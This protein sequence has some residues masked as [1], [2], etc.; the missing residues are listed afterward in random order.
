MNLLVANRIIRSGFSA[1]LGCCFTFL[2]AVLSCLAAEVSAA[3]GSVSLAWSANTE[4]NVAGYRLQYGTV[5]G[6]YPESMDVGKVTTASAAGLIPGSTYYFTVVAYNT[7]GQISPPSAEVSYLVP[8][9]PNSAPTATAGSLTVLEDGEGSITLTGTDAENDALIFSVVTGPTRGTLSGTPPNL[10]YRPNANANGNDSFTFRANDGLLSSAVATVSLTITPVNDVPV[11]TARTIS[12]NEDTSVAVDLTGTDPDGDPLSYVVVSGPAK[13]SLFGAAPTLTY[14]PNANATGGDSFTFRVNDGTASSANATVTLNILPVNDP[15]V[16]S[17]RTATTAEDV[18]VLITLAA[19][20]VESGS[21]TYSIVGQPVNGTLSGTPPT[22]TY[23]PK[24][25]FHGTDSFTFRANDGGASS[26]NATVNITVSPVNDPPVAKALSIATRRDTAVAIQLAGSDL[27]SNPLNFTVL[28]QPASGTLSG[29][30]PNLSYLPNAGYTG[31]DSFIYRANDGTA[32]SAI[33]TVSISVTAGNKA[34]VTPS[35]SLI[36]YKNKAL[37]VELAAIHGDSSELTYRVVSQP[38]AGT[39]TGTPPKLVFKPLRNFTGEVSFSYVAN[40]GNSDSEPVA[41]R[42]RVKGSNAHPKAT[43]SAVT[44]PWNTGTIIPLAGNDPDG[45]PLTFHIVR[46]P[47][48]G[49]LSGV[50]PNLT[51][52]PRFGFRGK[53]RFSFKVSDG[54]ARSVAAMVEIDVVNPD[55]RAPVAVELNLSGPVK[56]AVPV[57]LEAADA[58]GDP[59]SYRV[60]GRPASGRLSGRAPNLVFRP[61]A[62]FTGVVS[63]T[64]VANDGAMD[65]EPVTVTIK[66][67]LPEQVTALRALQVQAIEP[68][69]MPRLSLN[70]DPARPGILLF[71]VSGSPG[72]SYMLQASP[73]L[74][75][76]SDAREVILDGSGRASFE[77]A[78]PAGSSRGFFRLRTP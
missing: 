36:T 48:N 46:K 35:K 33:A 41:V 39:L 22:V 61:K 64:Y 8:A 27:E 1:S 30:P 50:H 19:T 53:D 24:P 60:V 29:T 3:T 14:Q 73:D 10:I 5:S 76:W 49:T 45:D 47:A 44:V 28:S 58:D 25:N 21:L 75:I 6:V 40:N 67:G 43:A 65:S 4:S 78:V 23:T 12:T 32:D 11:A 18:P 2:I 55:N 31:G 62:N 38:E 51:Y 57:T 71:S 42:I 26:A 72:G 15:P 37:A 68:M 52:T 54:H 7:A 69:V 77:L 74:R 20:D 66:I 59:L 16:A 17:G 56:L 34:P 9:S 70:A 13:G 63:F